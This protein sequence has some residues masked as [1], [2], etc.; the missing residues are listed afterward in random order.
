MTVRHK[1]LRDAKLSA[2]CGE[3]LLPILRRAANLDE[4]HVD[5]DHGPEVTIPALTIRYASISFQHK[6]HLTQ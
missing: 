1:M 3:V 4:I 2:G 5:I 6:Y